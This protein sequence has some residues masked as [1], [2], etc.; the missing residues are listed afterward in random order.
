[1]RAFNWILIVVSSEKNTK[2]KDFV[3]IDLYRELKSGPLFIKSLTKR[4][5]YF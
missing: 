3:T 2:I 5:R 1:M 4:H